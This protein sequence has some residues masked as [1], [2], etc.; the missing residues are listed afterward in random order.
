MTFEVGLRS[1]LSSYMK[2]LQFW[3]INLVFA[4]FF[5]VVQ[6]ASEQVGEVCR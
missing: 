2:N 1:I 5:L 4:F 3:T 6:N